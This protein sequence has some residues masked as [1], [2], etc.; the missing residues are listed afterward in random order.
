MMRMSRMVDIATE[1]R[2]NLMNGEASG[3]Y[4][5]VTT[6]NL[7]GISIPRQDQAVNPLLTT[8][9]DVPSLKGIR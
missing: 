9:V 2:S 4:R 5:K 3:L 7:G 1:A 6:V 8:E